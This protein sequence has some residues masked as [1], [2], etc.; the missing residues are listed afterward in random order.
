MVCK[1][2]EKSNSVKCYG[3]N[4]RILDVVRYV[5][6][7]KPILWDIRKKDDNI[8]GSVKRMATIKVL[9]IQAPFI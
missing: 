8:I 9:Q 4:E 6:M 1:K 3:H 5:R 2:P 7:L